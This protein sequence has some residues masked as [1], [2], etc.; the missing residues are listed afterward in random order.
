MV[1]VRHIINKVVLIYIAD[2]WTAGILLIFDSWSSALTPPIPFTVS[3]WIYVA[4]ISISFFLLFLDW[5]KAKNIIASRDISYAFTSTIASRYYTLRSYSH[6]CFFHQIKRQSKLIDKIAFFVFFTFKG[7]KRLLFAEAP[8]LT[9]NAL[10]LYSMVKTNKTKD[11]L[12][13]NAYGHNTI[14]RLTMAL[15]AITL[16]FFVISATKSAIALLLYIPLLFHIRGNLKEYCCH[17]IDKRIEE[18]LKKNS[19]KRRK[20]IAK[21]KLKKKKNKAINK[22]RQPTLPNLEDNYIKTSHLAPNYNHNSRFSEQFDP[23]MMAY[24]HPNQIPPHFN[25]LPLP[26]R[27]IPPEF[28]YN[29]GF[30]PP[31][32]PELVHNSRVPFYQPPPFTNNGILPAR[33]APQNEMINNYY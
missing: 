24:R 15:M 8:R 5:R 25:V 16:L 13:L 12:H 21:D 14:E 9:I 22:S 32:P 7:W 33:Y 18:L 28:S 20:K 6:Y 2:L 26:P 19:R 30:R 11:W 3:K 29:S 4:C 17:K 1:D 31:L 27:T 23:N 10:T